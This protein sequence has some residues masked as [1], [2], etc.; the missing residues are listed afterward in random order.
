M[1][2][3]ISVTYSVTYGI[4]NSLPARPVSALSRTGR[5]VVNMLRVSTRIAMKVVRRSIGIRVS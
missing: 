2:Y 3:L 1:T 4:L 5:G